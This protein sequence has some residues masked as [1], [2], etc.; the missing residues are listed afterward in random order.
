MPFDFWE[1]CKILD[2]WNIKLSG[3][4]MAVNFISNCRALFINTNLMSHWNENAPKWFYIFGM[5]QWCVCG[6]YI[7]SFYCP[8]PRLDWAG[9]LCSM[10]LQVHL[11]TK[12][13]SLSLFPSDLSVWHWPIVTR[14]WECFQFAGL[15][16]PE[17]KW[18]QSNHLLLFLQAVT[19]IVQ[20]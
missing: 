13:K 11:L 2:E 6:L 14:F 15:L 8:L 7:I 17:A 5:F 3:V 4:I 9:L 20:I 19:N 18:A 16:Y 12:Y 1:C 10:I